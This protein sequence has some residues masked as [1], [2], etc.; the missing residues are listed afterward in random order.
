MTADLAHDDRARRSRRHGTT[1]R[2]LDRPN[3]M[4]KIPGTPEGVGGD[5]AGDLRGDQRQRHAAVRGRGVRGGRRGLHPRTRASARRRASRSTS[6]RSRRFFVSRVDTHVDKQLE[7]L[8]RDDLPARRR[9][10][11][12]APPTPISRSIFSGER[13]EALAAAGAAVQRPLWA[14]TGVKNPRY[15]GHDVRRRADRA[16]TPS[17][18]CRW[19]RSRPSAITARWP[20]RPPRTTR[21]PSWTRC[22]DAG[23][24]IEPGHG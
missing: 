23:I 15:S 5:R 10:R 4:I 12:P 14:S 17:T 3:V 11:T 16:R 22:A 21:P 24:D 8:G 13:W 1:G 19:R 20:G 2:R 18:R 9:S 7:A 6:T